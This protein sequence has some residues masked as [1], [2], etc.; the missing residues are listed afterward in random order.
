[1]VAIDNRHY[2]IEKCFLS[3][4]QKRLREELYHIFS[5]NDPYHLQ[6]KDYSDCPPNID[7]ILFKI[8]INK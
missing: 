1:M 8:L 7:I 2:E 3:D 4:N 6:C 5:E